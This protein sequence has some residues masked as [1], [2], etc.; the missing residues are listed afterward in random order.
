MNV[1]LITP[2]LN[3]GGSQKILISLLNNLKTNTLILN[4][5]KKKIFS[6]SDR[7]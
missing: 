6:S 2:N 7:R 1:L 3:P 4:Y 5:K